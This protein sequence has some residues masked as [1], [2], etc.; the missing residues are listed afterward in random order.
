MINL[1]FSKIT[2]PLRNLLETLRDYRKITHI[3][4]N[5]NSFNSIY[6]L[7]LHTRNRNISYL[8]NNNWTSTKPHV[9]P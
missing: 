6:N 9:Q 1:P 8:S 7:N 2:Q 5:L 4:I 3:V